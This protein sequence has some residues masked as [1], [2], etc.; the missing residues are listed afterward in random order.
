M[1][2]KEKI[3]RGRF[4]F[5]RAAIIFMAQSKNPKSMINLRKYFQPNPCLLPISKEQKDLLEGFVANKAAFENWIAHRPQQR[6]RFQFY[7]PLAIE[8][9]FD[10][11]LL[12]TAFF[13]RTAGGG[14]VLHEMKM[15]KANLDT[16][17]ATNWRP[18][19][20]VIVQFLRYQEEKNRI[21]FFQQTSSLHEYVSICQ[22]AA[23]PAPQR[24]AQDINASVAAG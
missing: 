8:F 3:N 13:N 14:F 4:D 7:F 10:E 6:V 2:E 24:L 22:S 19:E 23:G 11:F 1:N 12:F 16:I 21:C 15:T 17:H 18:F 20:E 9:Y 5:L